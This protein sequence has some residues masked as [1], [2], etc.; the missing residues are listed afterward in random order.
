MTIMKSCCIDYNCI[1]CCLETTMP[2]SYQDIERIKKLGFKTDFFVIESDGWLQLKNQK[3][4]CVFHNG[5]TCSIYEN[6]P[7]GCKLYPVIYDKDKKRAVFDKDCP[8]TKK[9]QMK[10]SII[11]ELNTL[12]SKLEYERAERK[13]R[14]FLL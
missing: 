5:I 13:K 7:K 6:R 9:F 2:I 14:D 12:V 11:R 4:R 1:Q 10:K 3:G 8:N